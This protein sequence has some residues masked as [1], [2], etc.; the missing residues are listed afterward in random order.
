MAIEI[1]D[2]PIKKRVIVHSSVSFPPFF[3]GAIHENSPRSFGVVRSDPGR[4]I[5]LR[6]A[7]RAHGPG[8]RTSCLEGAMARTDGG[9][10]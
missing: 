8:H 1:V 9:F 2:I 7:G 4:R 6:A 3:P 10:G 5:A